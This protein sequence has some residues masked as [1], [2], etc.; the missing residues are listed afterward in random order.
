MN[1]IQIDKIKKVSETLLESFKHDNVQGDKVLA[2]YDSKLI[3]GS[4]KGPNRNA[5]QDRVAIVEISNQLSTGASLVVAVLSDGMGGMAQGEL[6]ASTTLSAFVAY[7][8]LAIANG[9]GLKK[10]SDEAFTAHRN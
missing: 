10:L 6:A 1:K 7:V 4:R 2:C 9:G 3:L 8:A 5:N